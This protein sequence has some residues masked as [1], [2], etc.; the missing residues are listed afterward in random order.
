M[1]EADDAGA[2]RREP[3]LLAVFGGLIGIALAV[4]L[5]AFGGLGGSGT[6]SASSSPTALVSPSASLTAEAS[7]STAPTD[8]LAPTPEVTLAPPTAA[9]TAARTAAPTKAPTPTATPNTRPAITKFSIPS[10]V[11]C[12]ILAPTIH[13]SWTIRNATGVT[14]SIDGGGLYQA[15]SG[16]SGSDDVPFGCSKNVPAHTYTLRTT[17]GSGPAATITKSVKWGAMQIVSFSMSATANCPNFNP[18]TTIGINLNYEIKYAT[19]AELSRDGQLY[20]T[21]SGKVVHTT[22]IV[23]DCTQHNQDFTLKTTGG[24]G[25]AATKTFRV[26]NALG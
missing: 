16:T 23:Y 2:G 3:W 26:N 15:Y 22:G 7:P 20:S 11:D 10:V 19:G 4:A 18:G 13:I 12:T 25:T 1:A 6:A 5:V 8:S 9:P 14:L 17:G 24:Y 21:Y